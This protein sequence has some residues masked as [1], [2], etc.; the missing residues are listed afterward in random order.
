MDLNFAERSHTPPP[1][2]NV[3]SLTL[4]LP[5]VP[6]AQHT[7]A[8]LLGSVREKECKP[9]LTPFET[10]IMQTHTHQLIPLLLRDRSQQKSVFESDVCRI[11]HSLMISCRY[12]LHASASNFKCTVCQ[13]TLHTSMNW[14]HSCLLVCNRKIVTADS[15]LLDCKCTLLRLCCQQAP[16]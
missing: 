1:T 7:E 6:H 3:C 12:P 13:Y 4:H 8:C 9:L 15:V 14:A 10:E 11:C 16:H 5:D 2:K